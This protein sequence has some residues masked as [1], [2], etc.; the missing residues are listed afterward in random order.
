M[1]I[2]TIA[3]IEGSLQ[4]GGWKASG[5]VFNDADSIYFH[6]Q[7][8]VW[9]DA[10]LGDGWE[11]LPRHAFRGHLI[12]D[13]W[14][15]TFQSSD[16][17]FTAFTAQEF[18]KR[19]E[20]QG[21]FYK[22][23]ASAP[24]NRHQIIDLT[25]AKIVYELISGHSNLMLFTEAATYDTQLWAGAFNSLPWID[26]FVTLNLDLTNSSAV[27]DYLVKAGNFW[28]R[29][30]EIANIDFYLIYMDKF[31]RLNY[32]PHPMFQATLPTSVFTITSSHL[33]EPLQFERRNT[34]AV[35][36]IK[37]HGA[38]PQ[39][40]QISG[41]YPTNATAG[42]IIIKSDYLATSSA[43]MAT[44]AT[45]MYKFENRDF[46]ITAKL[47]GAAGLLLDLLDRVAVTYTSSVD[48]IAWSAKKFW[49][50]KITVELKENFNAVTTLVLDAEAA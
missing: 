15:K 13:A 32:V 19:G 37:L 3:T 49:I 30:Q 25:Y 18:M 39:G 17:P 28:Q 34:E 8:G 40:L 45:R 26:G 27:S 2:D 10:W 1:P 42:P 7:F 14:T 20:V 35:G 21:I 16:A 24:A 6:R 47:P 9:Y 33:L 41:K 36:Q 38:T 22:H 11:N 44:I 29:L 31:N 5:A 12:P 43:L 23:V 48:G 50:S 46:T 4:D